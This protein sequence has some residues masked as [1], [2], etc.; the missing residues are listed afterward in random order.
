MPRQNE[1][2]GGGRSH[3]LSRVEREIREV[4]GIYLIS[5]FRGE[6]P[7]IVTVSRVTVSGDIRSAKVLVTLM[8]PPGVENPTEETMKEFNAQKKL[9]IAELQ[10][11][12]HEF[13]N[14][15][16]RKLRLRYVP[17][18]SF[19]YDEGF[20]QAMKVENVLRQI[21]LDAKAASAA[22]P[23]NSHESGPVK[24]AKEN[25]PEEDEN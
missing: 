13:Q 16:N 10:A 6:L 24:D 19:S 15:L 3:R 23:E 20:E 22:S 11:H 2:R 18:I 17:R 9:A 14:E 12:A 7:G 1:N 8:P 21:S 25:A 5:G 4:I